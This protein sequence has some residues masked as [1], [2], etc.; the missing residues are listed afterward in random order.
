V[1]YE[2]LIGGLLLAVA[3]LSVV[4][5]KLAKAAKE[6]GEP[7]YLV[8][9]D[10]EM[11]PICMLA[12]PSMQAAHAQILERYGE[13]DYKARRITAKQYADIKEAVHA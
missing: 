11:A 3:V 1:G 6:A 9:Y 7:I 5:F 4:A 8:V 10:E 13:G 12:V 2:L